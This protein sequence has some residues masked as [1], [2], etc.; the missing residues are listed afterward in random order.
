MVRVNVRILMEHIAITS[1]QKSWGQRKKRNRFL[2]ISVT[3]ANNHA[4]IIRPTFNPELIQNPE[5]DDNAL[6]AIARVNNQ[7]CEFT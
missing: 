4:R 5:S 3:R 6:A 1:P 7:S 2:I